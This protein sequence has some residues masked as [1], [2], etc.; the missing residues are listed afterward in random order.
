M[1]TISNLTLQFGKRILFDNVNIKFYKGNC[2]GIIG[3]NGSG[4][5]TLL[6]II[7]GD[8]EY[9][10]GQVSIEKG[11]RISVLKQE[12]Y[13]YDNYK[14]IDTVIM[15]NEKIYKIKKKMDYIYSKHFFTEKDSF[16][17]GELGLIYE[18]MGGWNTENDAAILLSNLG[19]KVKYH[20]QLM[21]D[22][23]NKM[24]VRVLLAQA[25]FGNP[26]ILLLDEP[27][28]NLDIKTVKWLEDFLSNYENTVLVVSHDRHFLDA[29]CT[30]I[31]D[32]DYSKINIITG[33]YSF[34]YTASKLYKKQQNQK[35]KKIE[36]KR[37]ELKEFIEKFS[38][39]AS[40]A[41]Q[42]TA[43]KKML[44]KLNM[45][46]FIPSSRRYPVIIFDQKRKAGDKIIEIKNIYKS[47][48]FNNLSLNINRG[49]KIALLS[50]DSKINTI[51]F[52]LIMN[53]IPI[54]KGKILWGITTSISYLPLNYTN[55][56]EQEITIIDWLK[57]Y[58]STEEE[59]HDE[60]LRG[61]LGKMLF[62]GEEARKQ[63]S[64]LS[65]GEKMR[66]MLT[67]I[68][69]EKSNVLILYEPTNH[70]DI[71]CI[72]SLNR[73]LK[74]FKGTILLTSQDY[75]LLQT[76]CNRIIEFTPN[77]I[78]DRYIKYD[79]YVEE[80]YNRTNKPDYVHL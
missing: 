11:K 65:G 13:I 7:S 55:Y 48:I 6:K 24:K 17:V 53:K 63:I 10:Y 56:F 74:K 47:T 19:I 29:V 51:F 38:S 33:N 3:S 21:S 20:D 36:E 15:G 44:D 76:V 40:K 22:I 27:T 49:D 31:C 28:N 78:Y 75:Q 73:A 43:R 66:C 37:K 68:M 46:E 61:L 80:L 42:A 32:I 64:I 72:T 26:D 50:E 35:N 54:D 25:I 58:A 34:W 2:Y 45:I 1:I 79:E 18:E 59:R 62:S 70:L 4:K 12:H 39:N 5:S 41:K 16:E 60:Y 69:L 30:H 52:E 77:K 71:E 67:K 8:L 23:D 14:V 9:H 57:Q